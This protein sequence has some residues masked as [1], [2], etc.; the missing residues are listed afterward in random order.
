MNFAVG[1]EITALSKF[2]AT[3]VTVVRFLSCMASNVDL[4]STGTHKRLSTD[5]AL[6]WTFSSMSTVVVREMPM[7]SE[8]PS[9]VFESASERLLPVVDSHVGLEITLLGKLLVASLYGTNEG[10]EASLHNFVNSRKQ[11]IHEYVYGS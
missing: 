3:D 10:L 8:R 2:L 1:S 6:E 5:V 11:I 4:K 9:T 7:C